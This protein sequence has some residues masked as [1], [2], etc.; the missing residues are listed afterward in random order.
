MT[1]LPL[2]LPHA[3]T[4]LPAA[5]SHPSAPLQ[6]LDPANCEVRPAFLPGSRHQL[7]TLTHTTDFEAR[8]VEWPMFHEHDS[9]GVDVSATSTPGALIGPGPSALGLDIVT[10]RGDGRRRTLHVR[11]SHRGKHPIGRIQ[12]EL[13]GAV[14][15]RLLSASGP[16]SVSARGDSVCFDAIEALEPERVLQWR[17]E[18][19]VDAAAHPEARIKVRDGGRATTFVELPLA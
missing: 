14:G 7:R 9:F 13:H 4:H 18:L 2:S 19:E 8:G 12:L 6:P 1:R 15:A 16:S 3:A 17:V 5:N 10:R 11:V